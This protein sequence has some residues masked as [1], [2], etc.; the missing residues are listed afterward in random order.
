[1]IRLG[2]T[3]EYAAEVPFTLPLATDPLTGLTGHVFTLGEVKIRLPGAGSWIDV[4][5]NK[6]VEKGYGRFAARLPSGQTGVAGI[7]S[8][9]ADVG[10][11]QPYRGT[12]T[13]SALG[14]DIAEG[15][16]GYLM[17]YLPD[18]V[19]PVYGAPA[20]GP[21]ASLAGAVARVCYQDATYVDFPIADVVEFENGLY[22][23]PV[24]A[25]STI[26]RGKIYYYL[27]A[28]GYQRFE[29]YSTVLGVSPAT[30]VV[31]PS[32]P[33]TI[34]APSVVV[35]PAGSQPIDHVAVAVNRLCQYARA[36][37]A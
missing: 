14:G 5:V 12:E 16:T 21:F 6:I 3:L 11:T 4:T 36:K 23:I 20:S 2:E 17:A 26:L 1:M 32:S 25:A 24:S 18:A 31:A 27:A 29:G 8:L 19:D 34:A 22:G 13:I 28:D 7:V 15:D 9:F 30:V 33:A 35:G 10:G 37:S